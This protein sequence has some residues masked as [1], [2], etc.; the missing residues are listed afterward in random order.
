VIVNPKTGYGWLDEA[1]MGPARAELVRVLGERDRYGRFRIY[2]PVTEGGADIYVHAKIMIVD[3]VALR[4]GSA[5]LNNRSM[6][7]DSECDLLVDCRLA[8]NRDCAGAIAK[9]RADLLGEHLGRK[10]EDVHSLCN[11]QGSLI[12]TI[13]KLRGEGRTLVPF[14]PPDTN[15]LQEAVANSEILDPESADQ[16]FEPIARRHLLRGLKRR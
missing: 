16:P 11:Q 9:L 2:N 5:N 7:L 15:A 1:V 8:A 10:P 4:V 13:E 6:G 12:R 14:D 3:D